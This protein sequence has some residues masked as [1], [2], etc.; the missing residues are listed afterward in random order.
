MDFI[1]GVKDI[2]EREVTDQPVLPPAPPTAPKDGAAKTSRFKASWNRRRMP[3]SNQTAAGSIPAPEKAKSKVEQALSKGSE[4]SEREK[5]HLE[6]I[7]KM[8]SMN[9]D[10]IEREREELL[11]NMDPGI[12]QALL[13]RAEA[14]E[15]KQP[16]EWD[17]GS[18]SKEAKSSQE[19]AIG[20]DRA[21]AT[22]GSSSSSKNPKDHS[23]ESQQ[24][25]S[26]PQPTIESEQENPDTYEKP[27][28]QSKP[29]TVRFEQPAEREPEIH[30]DEDGNEYILE[31]DD[32]EDDATQQP[33]IDLHFPKPPTVPEETESDFLDEMH[34]K[35]FPDLEV[36][37]DKLAWM[38][39]V[40]EEEDMK[41]Y[42]E[43]QD[44]LAPSELRFDFVGKLITP[45][46]S[47]QISTD[48]GLHHHGD[49]PLAAGYTIAELA[50][51]SRSTNYSQRCIAIRT[52]GRILYRLGKLQYGKEISSGLYGLVE[53]ARV[54]ETLIEAADE[55]RTRSVAVRAYATEALWLWKGQGS[56][57]RPA[58]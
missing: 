38:R 10:E 41:E 33:G 53:H 44:S 15:I 58:V 23:S 39:P 11:R 48:L 1:G 6:N 36:E 43:Y 7:E 55:N 16:K 20:K 47:R 27:K 26:R 5:I 32:D 54:N 46:Q 42:S 45:R 57:I 49:A 14:A 17:D 40:S 56:T 21:S 22:A 3:V 37:Q 13:R 52:L 12:L 28:S 29:R 25:S 35:Y 24:K 19:Q 30:V 2:V 9:A 34:I 8:A 18:D 51:L 4:L 50:H 31:E